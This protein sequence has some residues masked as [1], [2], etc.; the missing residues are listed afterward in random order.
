MGKTA[1]FLSIVHTDNATVRRPLREWALAR[2]RLVMIETPAGE[3]TKQ[4]KS[5]R[6]VRLSSLR[7]CLTDSS[8]YLSFPPLTV[9][10]IV[11]SNILVLCLRW[12]ENTPAT[13]RVIRNVYLW[14]SKAS[15]RGPRG[16]RFLCF[17][18]IFLLYSRFRTRVQFTLPTWMTGMRTGRGKSKPRR[19]PIVS[20]RE[21]D[22]LIVYYHMKTL[23]VYDAGTQ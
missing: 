3:E 17:F 19:L 12:S 6:A 10:M 15:S 22:N 21:N 14:A 11:Y 1:T 7:P 23:H 13:P 4:R 18:S 8:S 20:M 5:N 9:K 2:A 16:V